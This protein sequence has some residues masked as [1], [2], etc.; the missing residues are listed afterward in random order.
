MFDDIDFSPQIN[1]PLVKVIDLEGSAT[2]QDKLQKAE[3]RF[4]L[5]EN[6]PVQVNA[7]ARDYKYYELTTGYIGDYALSESLLNCEICDNF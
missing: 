4:T 7:L 6:K 3:L 2:V 1:T 5:L